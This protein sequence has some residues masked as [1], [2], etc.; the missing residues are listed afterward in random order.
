MSRTHAPALMLAV[1]PTSKGFGW[2][3]F[4]GPQA[5][6]HWGIA[7]ARGDRSTTSMKRFQ[8]LLDQYQPT[9]LLLEKF[10]GPGVRRNDRLRDLAAS[11]QGT[12]TS[13]DM[14]THIYSRADIGR[15]VAGNPKTTRHKV[16]LAVSERL[17]FLKMRLP[18]ERKVWESEKERQC[19]FDAVALGIAHYALA[20]PQN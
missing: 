13:R 9:I 12:A 8:Q 3:L 4:E 17:P 18:N 15:L 2:A 20:H 10:A 14:G 16:A 6:V 1:H 5:L 7:S 11:M 19:L